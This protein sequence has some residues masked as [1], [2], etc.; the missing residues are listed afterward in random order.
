MIYFITHNPFNSCKIKYHNFKNKLK[1]CLGGLDSHAKYFVS[2]WFY[3]Q[4]YYMKNR[5]SKMISIRWYPKYKTNEET[6]RKQRY[7][8]WQI[9]HLP[10][11]R[12]K[13]WF[14]SVYL[15]SLEFKKSAINPFLNSICIY[16]IPNIIYLLSNMFFVNKLNNLL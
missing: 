12:H 10:G 5:F 14:L 6:K 1:F 15:F 7:Q 11:S 8:E 3:G 13:T 9:C 2:R 16:V 4:V